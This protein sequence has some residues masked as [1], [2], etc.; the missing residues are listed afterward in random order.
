M[1]MNEWTSCMS[2]VPIR[3]VIINEALEYLQL[4]DDTVK[5]QIGHASGKSI[6]KSKKYYSC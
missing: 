3:T 5:Y 6:R 4:E 1:A 2:R